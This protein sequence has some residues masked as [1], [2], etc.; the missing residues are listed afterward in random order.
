M[1]PQV[2]SSPYVIRERSETDSG[3][4]RDKVGRA[5]AYVWLTLGNA[6]T[7]SRTT[8]EQMAGHSQRCPGPVLRQSRTTTEQYSSN[9]PTVAEMYPYRLH[10]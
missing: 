7:R 10:R 1:S 6:S 4:L 2:P 5:S 9:I 8:A 3:Q